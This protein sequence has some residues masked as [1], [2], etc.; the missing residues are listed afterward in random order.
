MFEDIVANTNPVLHALPDAAEMHL[1]TSHSHGFMNMKQ[2]LLL[3]NSR[4]NF[5]Y[6]YYNPEVVSECHSELDKLEYEE[7]DVDVGLSSYD[8]DEV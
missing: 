7:D 8:E 4:H 2:N 6:A 3:L 5:T 1:Y